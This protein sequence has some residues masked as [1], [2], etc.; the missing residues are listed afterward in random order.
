M[1]S[2]AQQPALSQPEVFHRSVLKSS[3]QSMLS[4]RWNQFAVSTW[5]APAPTIMAKGASTMSENMI[6]L[7]PTRRI[8]RRLIQ[9]TAVITAVPISQRSVGGISP[10]R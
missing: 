2:A 5:G 9:V 8:P 6:E 4:A 3:A 10:R 1:T 7:K